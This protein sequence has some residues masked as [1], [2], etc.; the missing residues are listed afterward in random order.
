VNRGP[1]PAEWGPHATARLECTGCGRCWVAVW[2]VGDVQPVRLE[3]PGCGAMVPAPQPE[4]EGNDDN[5]EDQ[6]TPSECA[7]CNGSRRDPGTGGAAC[8]DCSPG[9]VWLAAEPPPLPSLRPDG[10]PPIPPDLWPML[11]ADVE[12]GLQAAPTLDIRQQAL[13]RRMR[14]RVLEMLRTRA[15]EVGPVQVV[16]S[17]VAIDRVIDACLG[18]YAVARAAPPEAR[19]VLEQVV[20]QQVQVL[21]VLALVSRPVAAKGKG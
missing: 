16:A 19:K 6:P 4:R 8:P 14:A 2:P 12:R 5:R 17:T 10:P 21:Q 11:I 1:E 13:A 3:C 15:A 7:R 20:T 18:L 9:L